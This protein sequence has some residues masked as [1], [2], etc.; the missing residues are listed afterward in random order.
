MFTLKARQRRNVLAGFPCISPDANVQTGRT[1]LETNADRRPVRAGL[2]G[3]AAAAALAANGPNEPVAPKSHAGL[4]TFL[5]ALFDPLAIILVVA[6]AI[7]GFVGQVKD[8]QIIVA[9]VFIG[10]LINFLQ[11]Y[12]SQA[13]VDRLRSRVLPTATVFRDGAWLEAPQRKIVPGD[14]I[15]LSAGD[16]VP[17]DSMLLASKDLHLQQ[18]ALT[19][20]SFPV[21]K[22]AATNDE[23]PVSRPD[24]PYMVFLGTNVVSGVAQ[25]VVATTG[26]RTVFGGIAERLALRPEETAFER[27]LRRFGGF[28]LRAVLF[29]LSLLLVISIAFHHNA[30]QSLLFAVAL[31]VGMTPEFLPMITSVTLGK[32]AIEMARR[33][34]IV[35][36]LASIQ[37]LGS[38]DVLCS[39]KTGTLTAGEMKVERAIRP[40]GSPSAEVL[41][42]AWLNSRYETGIRSPLDTAILSAECQQSTSY[43]KLDEI[44]FDF[45]RRRVSVV[46][47]R[48][49][50]RILISK[51][52]PEGILSICNTS[53][54]GDHATQ[55]DEAARAACQSRF[56]ELSRSGFRTLAVASKRVEIAEAYTVA[57]ETGLCLAGFIAFSDPPLKDAAEMLTALRADGV[58]MKIITGDNELVTRHVCDRVGMNVTSIIRGDDIDVM[59]DP[60][61]E[62]AAETFD[63]FARVSPMQKNRII[64]AL[65]RRGHVV[66]YMGDG[67]ND[68]P[69]LR[70]ADVGISV[71]TAVDV[72]REAADMILLE[73]GLQV[74]HAGILE[75][76]KAFGNIMKYVQMGTSS[77]LGNVISMAAG[78]FFLPFLP[79]LPTQ[80]LLNNFL[81]DI[82]QITIPTDNVDSAYL[83]SPQQW[84]IAAIRRFSLTLAP[85]SSLYD[86]LTFYVLLRLF[87]ADE[88]LFH[89][90]WFVESLATQTLVLFVIRTESSPWRNRPSMPLTATIALA[91]VAALLL[92]F[93]PFANAL[94][95]TPLPGAFFPFLIVVIATYLLLVEVIKRRFFVRTAQTAGA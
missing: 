76:R 45:E 44:P 29:L 24:S 46:M 21:E 55:L 82:S 63:V 36:H 59:T 78:S 65:K 77:N 41:T 31:A 83:R 9:V 14:L 40:D 93:S 62:H 28:I 69:S 73:P 17:A 92:P 16:L 58:A 61:L 72:A 13:A 12:R 71:A 54:N 22:R 38:I 95:F 5:G 87:H 74:L 3:A 60:A 80:I 27:G 88:A 18:S 85:L 25:A 56:E 49:T 20:E 68:A 15:W 1:V 2:T 42:L 37:N 90:G 89:T 34:V 23:Q 7:D 26:P 81:Y 66:G 67:I 48:G 75:G 33:K 11:T 53:Q 6:A 64:L 79:M 39:D 51:G 8:A 94:G 52:S 32:G 10:G 30:F 70:A 50:E 19:G 4:L 43:R 57:H 84:D 35:K 91:V 86:F 47:E